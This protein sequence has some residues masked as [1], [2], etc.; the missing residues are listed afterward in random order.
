MR[1]SYFINFSVVV[2]F[3]L[4]VSAVQA[5]TVNVTFRVDMQE[6]VTSPLGVHIAGSFQGWNPSAT[7]MVNTFADI[8]EYTTQLTAGTTIE[9]KFINGDAWGQ[10]ESVYGPCGA[11]NGNRILTIPANDTV[12]PS[13]CFGECVPCVLPTVNVTF[14]VDMS[15][16]TISPSG[17][18]IGGSFQ[19]PPWSNQ[20]MTD[21]GNNIYSITVA[22]EVG[23]FH[24]YKFING[25]SYETVPPQCGYGGYNNRYLTVPSS[26]TTLPAVCFGSCDPCQ[27]VTD[28]QVTFRV[29][30][31]DQVVSPEGVHIAGG[32]QGWDPGATLMTDAGNGIWEYTATLQSGSYHEY[33]FVNGITWDDAENVPWF[34]NSNG[35]RYIT[36]PESNVVLDAVCFGSCL[37]C[38]P[39]P[40][41]VTFQVDMSLELIS[42]DGVHL[43]GTFQGWDEQNLIPMTDIGNNIYEAT[44][45]LGEGEFHE[46]KFLNGNSFLNAEIVP[47][48]C[49][50]FS[51][52]REFFVPAAATTLDLV[53]F[54]QCG[55]C[56]PTDYTLNITAMLEGPF[57]T[58]TGL[59]DNTLYTSGYVP[60]SQPFNTAPWNYNGTEHFD[61][62]PSAP[63][64]DWVL[65]EL[66]DAYGDASNATSSTVRY[67]QAALL[68][69]DGSVVATDGS[70]PI[71]YTGHIHNDLFIALYTRN[72]LSVISGNWI[73]LDV[74]PVDYDFTLSADQA[75]NSTQKELAPGVFG[76]IAG[77]LDG[78]GVID[79]ADKDVNWTNDAGVQGYLPSDLNFDSPVNNQDKVDFW[80]PN[81]GQG[82]A[83][84]N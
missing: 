39:P 14:Q 75:Y 2:L 3:A 33:K 18:F 60:L 34:C 65:V 71:T 17:V 77:D 22:M 68:L 8:W 29:D 79:T 69:T 57:D 26:D 80:E 54:E 28:I 82:S 35:N 84:P 52:N 38:N 53:C 55:A 73:D 30:M 81:L 70:S 9:Y 62:S 50:N 40:V 51:G 27:S 61:L 4:M 37:V 46:Y 12:M 19:S 41:D 43:A 48:E 21:I 59:M 66:R 74:M 20:Q 24:E 47:G 64:V 25:S 67:R 23:T 32:F 83:V 56:V 49:A 72:H 1:K 58:L 11:G 13:V 7:P 31:S 16:E 6:Q 10:D 45:T 44:V 63:V 42:P 15:N 36:V 76:L 78:N 5:Q